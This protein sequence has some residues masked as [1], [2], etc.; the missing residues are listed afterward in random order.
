LSTVT[1]PTERPMHL[2]ALYLSSIPP[3]AKITRN[4]EVLKQD[5]IVLVDGIVPR[6]TVGLV[7]RVTI[8]LIIAARVGPSGLTLLLALLLEALVVQH[9]TGLLHQLTGG[10]IVLAGPVSVNAATV[11]IRGIRA[12]VII[13]RGTIGATRVAAGT[14]AGAVVVTTLRGAIA[15]AALAPALSGTIAVTTTLRGAIAVAALTP[16]LSGTIAVTTTLSGTI[17]VAGT[18][19]PTL[20]TGVTSAQGVVVVAA[21]AATALLAGRL[22]V[23]VVTG[24]ARV[25]VARHCEEECV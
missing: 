24:V 9:A 15:V 3:V 13:A 18:D 10:G 6:V 23:A 7:P 14:P 11:R 21:Q 22:I 12:K 20:A 17:G 25:T 8:G 19:A 16:A 4:L 1:Q 5:S 2:A